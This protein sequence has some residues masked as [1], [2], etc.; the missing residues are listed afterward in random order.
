MT[1]KQSKSCPWLSI[2]LSLSVAAALCG[3][4]AWAVG[5]PVALPSPGGPRPTSLPQELYLDV[6]LNGVAAGELVQFVLQ[7]GVLH[8][9]AVALRELGLKWPGSEGLGGM[10]PLSALPGLQAVYD[11]QRQRVALVAPVSLL[12]RPLM[13][14][15][16]QLAD[17]PM[18]DPSTLV[19]GLLLNY[20]LYAQNTAGQTSVSGWTEMRLFGAGGGLWSNTMASQFHTGPSTSEQPSNVRLDTFWQRDFSDSMTTLTVGDTVTGALS[21]SRALRIGGLRLS[22]N[23]SLQPYRV[24]APLAYF[25]GSAVLPSTVDLFVNGMRQS[26]QQ[27]QPGQFQLNSVPS[28]NGSGQAQL[29][30]TDINGQQRLVNFDLYGAPQLLQAGLSD[31]SLELGKVRQGYGLRSFDYDDKPVLSG[32]VRHGWSDEATL[33]A[34]AETSAGLQQGG[35]G[36]VWLLGR[37]AGVLSASVA[38]SQY[39]G[40]RGM[41][42]GLGYQWSS[43]RF[44]LSLNTLRANDNYRDVASLHNAP[45]PRISDSAFMGMGSPWG[46]FGLGLIRQQYAGAESTR[47]ASLS[48]SRQ[49]GAKSTLSLSANR[50]LSGERGNTF[51]LAWS[52]QV[53]RQLTVSASVRDNGGTRGLTLDAARSVP[54]D[55]GG[56]G[57]RVQANAGD[58]A[59]GQAQVSQLG[60]YGQ[61]TAGVSQL[62][63]TQGS[64]STNTAYASANGGLVLMEGLRHATRR[65]DDA[66][67]VVSTDG[68][69]GVPVRLENRLIGETDAQGMLFVTRLNAYQRNRLSIDTLRLPPDMR[70]SRSTLDAVPVGRSGMLARFDM[71]RIL[72]V[73]VA[74]RNPEGAWLPT[75]SRVALEAP[76]APDG[77]VR[78]ADAVTVVGYDG[79]VYLEDPA[80]G[81]V[82]RVQMPD[83]VCRVLLP[84]SPQTHGLVDFGILTCQ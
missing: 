63:G 59:S 82:L 28:L 2:V 65:V 18:V 25:Q 80:P 38:V 61:W 11:A 40:Q 23:F 44:N 33:E 52:M 32:G 84:G 20:D 15:D 79:L 5:E 27:V 16:A 26:S 81:A 50:R 3:S 75:G 56:W 76:S 19:P 77:S 72:A 48:W 43:Q 31:W 4:R 6:T 21:W 8:A 30:I 35:V 62:R 34:H 83:G 64:A 58:V 57:W 13:T 39:D 49:L 7:Q 42:R 70:I 53:E 45:P 66:F 51:Y 1:I 68:V 22:R 71:R 55:E 24:T 9:N 54:G 69:A 41:Q 78:P 47:F 29:V 10:V 67:A 17:R 74:L 60:R 37:Q 73:Q 14:I 12:D 36:G 46:Q